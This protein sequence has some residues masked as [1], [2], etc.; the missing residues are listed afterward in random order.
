M[1]FIAIMVLIVSCAQDKVAKRDLKTYSIEQFYKN[2]QIGG[3]AFSPD[4]NKLVFHSNESGI[5]NLYEIDLRDGQ[6]RQVTQSTSESFFAVDYVPGTSHILYSADQGGNEINHLY[7]LKEDGASQDLTPGEQEKAVF[8]GWSQDKQWLYYL[9]NKRDPK[10]FDLYKMRIGTWKP[11][12]LYQNDQGLNF[13]GISWDESRLALQKTI[14]TSENQLFLFDR[15]TKEMTEISDPATPGSYQ[16]SGFSK[17]GRAFFYITDADREFAYLVRY[18][19]TSGE[20]RILF[21]SDWDVA[22]SY[23]SENETYRV[24]AVN[25]DGKNELTII[26]QTSG[27]AADFPDIPDGDVLAVAISDSEKRMR[28]TV[29]TSKAPVNLYVYDFENRTLRKITETL[30]PEINPDDLV[31][32]QVVRYPSFDGLEIP[33][34]YYQPHSAAARNKAPA[35]VWVHGG[36]G[37]Q[38]RTGYSALIQFLVNHGYAILAVNNRGSSGYGKTFYKMDDLNHGDKDLKDCIWGKKWLQEQKQIDPNKI[39]IIGGSYGGYMT[40]AA[41]AFH[42]DEF[43]VGVNIF[44][45]TNWLRTLKSIPPWWES[46]REALYKELG[47][48]FSADSVR[49]YNISPL[50]HADRVKNPVMVLQGANDPRVLQVESDEIVEAL[51]NN[52]VPVEYIIFPDEGH[53]FRKKENEIKGYGQILTFLD[54]YLK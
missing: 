17:N 9:S 44:G 11:Q 12:L 24:V 41:M 35:L 22:Y 21:E 19:L 28:L 50:F 42:P 27:K 15:K 51:R 33:A 34:I 40:M 1:V 31:V 3:G 48:P 54:Q 25:A 5:Y 18:D 4:E 37:G 26:D 6:K 32:A 47:D 10:F 53:G 45:V 46:M 39:G 36:P 30:N 43:Q 2:I 20:R 49:L 8:A 29:G 38:S 13:A 16:A 14:T 52:N 23:V 7:L